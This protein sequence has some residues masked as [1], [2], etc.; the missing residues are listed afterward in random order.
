LNALEQPLIADSA[1]GDILVT[2]AGALSS[3]ADLAELADIASAP[4][5]RSLHSMPFATL[6]HMHI[7][8]ITLAVE[9]MDLMVEFY[10]S[11]FECGLAPVSG[12]PLSKGRFADFELVVCPNSVARVV[13][14]QN[15][16]QF[17]LIVEDAESLA[18]RIEAAGGSVV[19]R[20]TL[21]GRA[22]V[23]VAD[24]EGNT[25]ELVSQ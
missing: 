3:G 9:D 25:Y 23:G 17:R 24:P 13:A 4:T 19:N 6:D 10:N 16:H 15:R 11:I 1:V 2:G 12:S 20:D 22:I 21:D 7:Q 18:S 8:R 5:A 14:D